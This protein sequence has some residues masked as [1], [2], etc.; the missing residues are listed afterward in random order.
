MVHIRLKIQTKNVVSANFE[1]TRCAVSNVTYTRERLCEST[2]IPQPY[3]LCY[4][5]YV[6]HTDRTSG[7]LYS[8]LQQL[9]TDPQVEKNV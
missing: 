2:R 4:K 3:V 7:I 8:S 6:L 9:E 5:V 1:E